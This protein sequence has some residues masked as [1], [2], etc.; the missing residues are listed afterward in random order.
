DL[1]VYEV[2]RPR[3]ALPFRG[4]GNHGVRV[5]EKGEGRAVAPWEPGDQVRP[6]WLS[7]DQAR[8]DP[9]PRQVL[10]QHER[11]PRLVARGIDGVRAE[12]GLEQ[13]GDLL[14]KARRSAH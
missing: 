11:S 2:A 1:V 3:V 13:R 8:F 14:A 10:L 7:C 6:L 5:A 4:I 9:V 12:E